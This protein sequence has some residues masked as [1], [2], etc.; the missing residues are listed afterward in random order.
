[1]NKVTGK[2]TA[3]V[4]GIETG[5][6]GCSNEDCNRECLRADPQLFTRAHFMGGKDCANHIPVKDRAERMREMAKDGHLEIDD[7]AEI[8]MGEDN[9]AYVQAWVWVDF[10]GTEFD[11]DA[12]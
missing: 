1:M 11:K 3:V 2:Y 12:A 9:G 8:S 4:E 10:S 5:L 7:N 6:G